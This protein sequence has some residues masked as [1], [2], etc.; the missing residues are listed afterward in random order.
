MKHLIKRIKKQD[1]GGEFFISSKFLGK[2]N[3]F[4]SPEE[5]D[6]TPT[7][8]D[9]HIIDLKFKWINLKDEK[10]INPLKKYRNSHHKNADTR[11]AKT[12]RITL[13]GDP[14]AVIEKINNLEYSAKI[15]KK[16]DK[17]YDVIVKI[18]G[19][20]S[21][22]LTDKIRHQMDNKLNQIL[23]GPPGTGKTYS[24]ITKAIDIVG[25]EY[26]SYEE[27]QEL[28]QNELGKRIEF[29]TMHQSFSYEDFVQGL[30]PKKSEDGNGI[31]FDYKNGVFK[32]ICRRANDAETGDSGLD[33]TTLTN[34]EVAQIMFFLSKFNGKM[35]DEKEA[36]DFLGFESDYKAF[37]GIGEKVGVKPNTLSNHRDKFDFMFSDRKN[38]SARKGWTPRNGEG[39][40]DNSEKW[41]YKEVYDEMNP[42][43]FDD[44]SKHVKTLLSKTKPITADQEG[45]NNHVI[46]LDEINRANIS[47]VFGELIAL[48]EK[49][50]RDGKLTVTLPSGEPFTVPSNLYIIGTMNTADKS[51]ALVDIALRRRFEFIPLYPDAAILEEV[52]NEK[53]FSPEDIDQRVHILSS[54]NRIIRA[55]KSVDFEIG[56]SYF[57][58]E[59]NLVDVVNKQILPLLNEYFM[60]DLRK[61]KD[62]IE[63]IQKDKEGSSIPKTGI[64]LN[65]RIWEERGLLEAE[66]VA[67]PKSD[68]EETETGETPEGE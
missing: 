50:K 44:V 32:E 13:D 60:Y 23:Y 27:A 14:I 40:L 56:H 5:E 33:A 18:L 38:Y 51:I 10:E 16:G 66:E 42:K 48:I 8:S 52:L 17:D 53:G 19:K 31:V 29:V 34:R 45:N 58:E 68:S 57:M 11:L 39:V 12:P 61:V 54:L 9:P 7:G 41:P 65:K 26:N 62:I 67:L 21:Y 37:L 47:R 46:I 22:L 30:K 59:D 1:T 20:H 15:H 64:V 4:L 6:P 3:F 25:L 28:F 2:N 63:K 24:T 35:K 43:S 49:D 36:N 55:K